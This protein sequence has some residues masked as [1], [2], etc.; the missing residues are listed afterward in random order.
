MHDIDASSYIDRGTRHYIIGIAGT[1]TQWLSS[2]YWVDTR[3]W[4]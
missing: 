2:D 3:D 1:E 4:T